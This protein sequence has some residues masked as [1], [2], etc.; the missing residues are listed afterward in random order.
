LISVFG[1]PVAMTWATMLAMSLGWLPNISISPS[2]RG[3]AFLYGGSVVMALL[4]IVALI[5]GATRW[6]PL[7]F[8]GYWLACSP[9]RCISTP[10]YWLARS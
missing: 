5:L 2:F 9:L 7:V 8:L 3:L 10:W 4:G 6:G 1:F